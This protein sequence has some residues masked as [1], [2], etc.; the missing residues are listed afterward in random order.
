MVVNVSYTKVNYVTL[1]QLEDDPETARLVK[2]EL[3]IYDGRVT[4]KRISRVIPKG[5]L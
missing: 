2:G 1:E 5:R 3:N 4:N